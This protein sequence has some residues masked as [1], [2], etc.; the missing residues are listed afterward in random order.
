MISIRDRSI[1]L[2]LLLCAL[3]SPAVGQDCTIGVYAE[4]TAEGNMAFVSGPY[5][6]F[7]VYVII[8][9][10]DLVK[11]ASYRLVLQPAYDGS[12]GV[13]TLF[14]TYGP[15]GRGIG[16]PTAGGENVG[17]GECA[18]GFGGANVLVAKHTVM[19]TVSNT[20]AAKSPTTLA[21]LKAGPNPD[22]DPTS[23]V[24]AGCTNVIQPCAEG[25]LLDIRQLRIATESRTFGQIKALY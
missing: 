8:R 2:L 16:I 14:S 20:V 10:E 17:L 19:L 24:Y 15:D 5:D 3:H 7:E 21:W 13:V 23:A 18:I 4:P 25:H 11:A 1:L 12:L 9:A 22:Q 6:P